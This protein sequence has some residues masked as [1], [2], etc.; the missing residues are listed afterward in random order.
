[1]PE[2]RSSSPR[3]GMRVLRATMSPDS[4]GRNASARSFSCAM[5]AT[6]SSSA[7]KPGGSVGAGGGSTTTGGG[8]SGVVG[9]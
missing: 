6:W 1:M 7:E 8:G 9:F 3:T 5:V 4:G 2:N